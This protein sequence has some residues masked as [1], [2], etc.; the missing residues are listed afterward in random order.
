MKSAMAPAL[1]IALAL[2]TANPGMSQTADLSTLAG[3][4]SAPGYTDAQGAAARFQFPSGAAMDSAGNAYVA[5]TLNNAIRKIAPDGTVTTF[6]GGQSGAADGQGTNA[7]FNFP[8]GV[9][10]D[11]SGNVYVADQSNNT[12]R[13]ITPGG[14][15]STL[16]GSPGARGA[17]DGSG[18]NA[19][20]SHPAGVAVDGA[21]NVYVA[22]T[23]NCTIR[24]I[25]S[26]GAVQT[27]A[28]KGGVPY[29]H[30][31]TLTGTG[32]T[33]DGVGT[34][35]LFYYPAG[36]AVDAATNIYVTDTGN[37]TI[38]KIAPGAIVSTLAGFPTAIGNADGAGT[39]ASFSS[40]KGVAVDGS[41]NLYVADSGNNTIRKISPSGSVVTVAGQAGAWGGTDAS[42][43]N[44]LFSQP[45]GV[46]LDA[47]GNLIV[48]D[49]VNC[50]IREIS[51]NGVVGTFAG[52]GGSA[53]SD[54][55]SGSEA[56]FFNP[57]AMAV[58][59]AT[60]LYVAD[61][62]NLTIRKVTPEGTVSVVAG[63]PGQSGAVNGSGTNTLLASPGGL[64]VDASGNLY[65]ADADNQIIRKIAPDGT[66]T[67]LAGQTGLTG[68]SDG[69]GTYA[70]FSSPLGLALDKSG[71]LYVADTGN[72]T[73]RVITPAGVVSTLAGQTGVT[74]AANG[75][76]TNATFSNPTAVAVDGSGNVYVAD[77]GNS[78]IRVIA[79][80]G[81][82]S[83]FAG[84]AG[85]PGAADGLGTNASFSSMNGLAV[86]AAGNVYVADTYNQ[87]IRMITPAG[88]VATVGGSA[89]AAGSADGVG[90]NALFSHPS[91]IAVDSAGRVYVADA[92]NNTIRVGTVAP[93][94]PMLEVA[95]G[96]GMVVLSWSTSATGFV[97]A[98]KSSL[99]AGSVWTV[100][101]NNPVQSGNKFFLTNSCSATSGFF[102]LVKQ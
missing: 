30:S 31:Y 21:G 57:V 52:P 45:S 19:L 44:A 62:L 24:M 32:G 65:I 80:G 82:V 18:T 48:A 59:G 41:G 92:F 28:G 51:T 87:T 29:G 55:G 53:G 54:N 85:N 95:G 38:R 10:V 86:D 4:P 1:S 90:T 26:T 17:S 72:E 81:G 12:I 66:A 16:A 36:I 96:A 75:V 25:N 60:N 101:T 40:P 34:N 27:L 63:Q 2:S 100:L 58:D 33:A 50:S 97:P 98:T 89:G 3:L 77:A 23:W 94:P 56:R 93:A 22:D 91:G 47:K 15:V 73:I 78:M 46:A 67:T 68:S 69:A 37:D 35:A 61:L 8:A 74:G 9:A 14:L 6:A 13:K 39:N 83:G 79:P 71:N 42:G 43:T 20:F 99:A 70:S 64:A 76:G 7:G 88:L 102:R 5:D 84:L 11:A 49:T